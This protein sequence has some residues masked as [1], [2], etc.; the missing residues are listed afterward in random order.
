MIAILRALVRM[1][2]VLIVDEALTG[3]DIGLEEGIMEYLRSYAQEHAVLL[4]TH[5]REKIAAADRVY[6]LTCGRISPALSR[7][8]ASARI[9]S[10]AG[11]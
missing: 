3:L 1:P 10:L 8:E 6:V 9:S 2:D 4:I 7:I 11:Y 5:D